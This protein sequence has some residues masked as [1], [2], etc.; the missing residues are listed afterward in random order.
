MKDAYG[1]QLKVKMQAIGDEFAAVTELAIGQTMEKVPIAIIRGYNW[2]LY[3]GGSAKYLSLI[4]VGYKCMFEG[5][6]LIS[7]KP[8]LAENSKS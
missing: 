5:V 6:P 8:G 4:R 3:E 1:C 2:I 7:E